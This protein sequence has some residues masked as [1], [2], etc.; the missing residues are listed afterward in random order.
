MR[1]D[2]SIIA[3]S[4]HLYMGVI[5]HAQPVRGVLH[6]Q[7]HA[8]WEVATTFLPFYNKSHVPFVKLA[9]GIAF[10]TWSQHHFVEIGKP[11]WGASVQCFTLWQQATTEIMHHDQS[12]IACSCHLY[13][14]AI[15]HTHIPLWFIAH[16]VPRRL[17][18]CNNKHV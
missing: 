18:G 17:R 15:L 1:Q 2:Y 11:E 12:I 4:C 8:D 3:C 16:T 7:H 5:L 9:P 10:T 13:M 14:G 6:I